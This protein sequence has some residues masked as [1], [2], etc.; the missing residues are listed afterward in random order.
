M[1]DRLEVIGIETKRLLLD[2]RL[3]VVGE[4]SSHLGFDDLPRLAVGYAEEALQHLF[5][6]D[7]I[8]VAR[9]QRSMRKAGDDLAVDK[10]A[11]AIE[12]DEIDVH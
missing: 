5:G 10:H 4:F 9:Q 2:L 8:A 3:E 7:R 11:V 6:R 12:N 1:R